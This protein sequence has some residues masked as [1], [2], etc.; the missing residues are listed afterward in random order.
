MLTAQRNLANLYRDSVALMQISTQLA[1]QPG[2]VQAYVVMATPANLE[3]LS[4]VGLAVDVAQAGPNDVLIAVQGQDADHLAAAL[5]MAEGL[6]LTRAESGN[7]GDV[8]TIPLRSIQMGL[9]AL[10]TANLALISTPGEYAAAEA[11]KAL[12]LGLNVMLFSDNVSLE[13]EVA[14]KRLAQSSGLLVMGPDCGTAIVDGVPLAFANVVR[15]GRIGVVGASGTGVQQITCLVDR[16]GAGISH[17]L[18]T[19]G[20]DLQS[21]VGGISMRTALADLAADDSTDVIVLVSKPPAA[22]VAALV[23]SVAAQIGKPVVVNFLGAPPTPHRPPLYFAET[24]AD[25]SQM[26]VALAGG[27]VPAIDGER[28]GG[29]EQQPLAA[30]A[31]RFSPL[32]R[33]VR[34]VYSG[35]TFCY[36]ALL[37]LAQSLGPVHSNLAKHPALR[38]Y[39]GDVSRG[40]TVIDLGDD[41]FTRGRPHPMIDQRLRA[42]RIVAEAADDSVAVLLLDVVL[43]YGA[44]ED[45]ATALAPAIVQARE[46]AARG[47]RH[48]AVVAF[49]CGT[50]GDPQQLARQ[51]AILAEAGVCLAESSTAAARLAVALAVNL[52]MASGQD[53]ERA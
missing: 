25:A 2:I 46:I 27:T 37:L 45:P 17:A 52:P 44:H 20:R 24:L 14:L 9:D 32:Q 38:L 3:M 35:G 53:G 31:C 49:V 6:L 47:G 30:I 39:S 43:G 11:Y 13:D 22:E 41:E 29:E 50:A 10:P 48:L 28:L 26:A 7:G 1:A 33:Y 21:A 18:G 40:H 8:R 51:E 5:E 42:A 23:L 16:L 4:A 34:G 12:R 36:E 19:G 15:R